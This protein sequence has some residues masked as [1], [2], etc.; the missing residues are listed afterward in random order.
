MS[1]YNRLYRD[2]RKALPLGLSRYNAAT[3][4]GLCYD[5]TE[6]PATRRTRHNTLYGPAWV[7]TRSSVR[8]DRVVRALQH[9]RAC[10][11]TLSGLHCHTVRRALRHAH[12][13]VG[14]RP[15]YDQGEAAT[16]RL[17]RYDT[18]GPA[19]SLSQCVHLVHPTQF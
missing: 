15:R 9:G 18:T 14:E 2:R 13:T 1:R 16:R 6:E 10:A 7:E 3:W 5:T 8:C 4:P 12:N 17:V 19:R 11:A